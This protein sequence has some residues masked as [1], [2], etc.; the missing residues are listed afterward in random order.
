MKYSNCWE[1][2]ELI[3]ETFREKS[4]PVIL[5]IGSGGDNSLSMLTLDPSLVVI[6]DSDMEQIHLINLKIAAIKYL[7]YEELLN[8]L[9]IRDSLDRFVL[10]K[11]KLRD[12]LERETL[13][14]WNNNISLIKKG[15]IHLGKFEKYFHIFRKFILP[16]ILSKKDINYLFIPKSLEEQR[17]F[18]NKKFNNFVW[19]KLFDLFF[20]KKTMSAI[21]RSK[22]YFK[23]VDGEIEESIFTRVEYALTKI[24]THNN[25]YLEYITRGNFLKNLPYYLLE[26]N[27]SLIKKNIERVLILNKTVIQYLSDTNLKFDC[28]N[29]SDIFEY[30]SV[31]ETRNHF[32]LIIKRANKEAFLIYWN[33]QVDRFFDDPKIIFLRDLSNNLFKKDRAFFYK[34]LIVGKIYV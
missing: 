1:D 13:L 26:D 10:Y 21:G 6:I 5:S 14:F 27:Y 4:K 23:Y 30:M 11:E 2:V 24:P 16:L 25:P 19:K 32:D 31:E 8:F 20:N 17:D 3:I 22:E 12:F 18:Y 34:R 7:S 28:F 9:G 15:I 29:L 33:M